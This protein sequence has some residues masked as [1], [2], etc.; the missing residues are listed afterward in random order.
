MAEAWLVEHMAPREPL[1]IVALSPS[2]LLESAAKEG[3]G[4][5][6]MLLAS[7]K[8]LVGLK[9]FPPIEDQAC[10]LFYLSHRLTQSGQVRCGSPLGLRSA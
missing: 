9:P 2:Y 6:R 5:A 10:G 1:P 7:T 8:A 3:A 4:M